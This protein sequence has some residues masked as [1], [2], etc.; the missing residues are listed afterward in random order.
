MHDLP[1]PATVASY[2]WLVANLRITSKYGG[3]DEKW[4]VR[5]AVVCWQ[6]WKRCCNMLFD[7]DFVEREDFIVHCSCLTEEYI[8][9]LDNNAPSRTASD[10]IGLG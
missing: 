9:C 7:E 1:R 5:F 6:L 3:N 4:Q 2:E 8:A 10:V